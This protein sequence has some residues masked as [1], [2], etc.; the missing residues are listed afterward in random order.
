[1][2]G[3]RPWPGTG[4]KG[5]RGQAGRRSR[6]TRTPSSPRA[7]ARRAHTIVTLEASSTSVLTP[8][9]PTGS[10]GWNG[11]GQSGWP[12]RSTNSAEMSAAKNTDSPPIRKRTASLRLSSTGRR[13]EGSRSG[14][15]P[16][17][18]RGPVTHRPNGPVLPPP[19]PTGGG[20]G[21]E[22][23]PSPGRPALDNLRL[24]VLFL[25]GG[26]SMFFAAL[27]SGLFVLPLGQPPPPPPLPPP[28]PLG[29]TGVHPPV[30]LPSSRTMVWPP[31]AAPR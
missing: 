24:A 19:P 20:D 7:S 10:R 1:M 26:E 13:G 18:K 16:P 8:V 27:I 21:P 3:P 23:E 22:R 6:F 28:L 29:V 15:S 17:P 5:G 11:G 9:T 4:R 12:S 31:R 30:L 14:P 2:G 25:I